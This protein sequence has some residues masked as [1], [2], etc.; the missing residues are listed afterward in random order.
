MNSRFLHSGNDYIGIKIC[1][2][3]DEECVDVA[4]GA[5]A[6]AIGFVFANNSPRCIDR[7]LAEQLL[8][9]I[10]NDVI[11]IAVLQDEQDLGSFCDWPGMLQ[12]CGNESEEEIL[13]LN[14]PVIKAF[15]W[16]LDEVLRWDSF[17]GLE[18]I[19]VDGGVGGKGE[20]FDITTLA[21]IMPRLKTSVIIAGGLTPSNVNQVISTASPTAVDVSSGIE[22][23]IGVKDPTLICDFISAIRG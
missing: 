18:A 11:P 13:E 9:Q 22:S 20:M 21:N 17:G 8:K 10:P 23:S 1:G 7:D 3:Q 6:D 15:K 2:L 16:D 5:G 12:L 19:L 4:V 14:L